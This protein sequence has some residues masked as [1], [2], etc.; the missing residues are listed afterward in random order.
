MIVPIDDRGLDYNEVLFEAKPNWSFSLYFET[1]NVWDFDGYNFRFSCLRFD[2]AWY[3]DRSH[4]GYAV[5]Y[6]VYD[7]A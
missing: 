2:D 6:D 1:P 5:K 7:I 3:V 4:D